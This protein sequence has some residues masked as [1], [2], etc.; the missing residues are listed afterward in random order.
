MES[1]EVLGNNL[2]NDDFLQQLLLSA[3]QDG[4]VPGQSI[5]K[6]APNA[7][8]V[9]PV[10]GF[11]LKTKFEGRDE[12]AF[13]N[14]CQSDQ[15][16]KPLPI[17]DEKLAEIIQ[18]M[19]ADDEPSGEF[20]V[21]MSLGEPHAEVDN[22]GHGCTAYDVVVHPDFLTEVNQ[23]QMLLGFFIGIVLQGLEHKYNIELNR[24]WK[25]LKNRRF[26]GTLPEQRVRAS[27]KPLI[28][29][30]NSE[31]N[32]NSVHSQSS[33]KK[34]FKD[35]PVEKRGKAPEFTI[36]AEPPSGHPD[37]LVAEIQLPDVRSAASLT[38]D[39][40]EDRI[41]L[42]TRSDIYFLDIYLPYNI[43][44]DDCGSQFNKK[45]KV[46]TITMPVQPKY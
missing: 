13:I 30:M 46:L 23:R 24:Q 40:G 3:G 32:H 12:K 34:S 42:E 11:C 7:K 16:P 44:Q 22:S 35:K 4:A 38:L 2:D 17:T 33:Q 6:D 1:H 5:N 14:V 43:D 45:T 9:A 19:E 37:F 8:S 15:L 10:P 18:A 25:I 29:E 21:P 36:L 39:L 26:V 31:E 27:S 41:L 28:M 20:R